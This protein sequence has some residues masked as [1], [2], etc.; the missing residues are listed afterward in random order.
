MEVCKVG[1]YLLTLPHKSEANFC[2]DRA[3]AADVDTRGEVA[4]DA[5][6]LEVKKI[7]GSI[8]VEGG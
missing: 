3:L 6:A 5:L 7:H 4:A 8:G 1:A 2:S